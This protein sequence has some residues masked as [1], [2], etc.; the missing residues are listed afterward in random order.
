MNKHELVEAVAKATGLSKV[1]IDRAVKATV[2]NISSA[3]SKG[4]KVTLVGFGT[5]ERRHRKE[6]I[7]VNPQKPAERITIPAKKAA[8][9]AP[10]SELREAVETGKVAAL[11]IE[12]IVKKTAWAEPKAKVVSK[13]SAKAWAKAKPKAKAKAWVKGKA[14]VKAKV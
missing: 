2:W 6:R 7:G 10:G 5:F 13:V 3:L 11:D 1:D 4:E 8:A 14:K 12:P 9:F